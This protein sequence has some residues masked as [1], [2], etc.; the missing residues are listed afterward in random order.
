MQ[1]GQNEQKVLEK[2]LSHLSARKKAPRSVFIILL[3]MYVISAGIVSGTAGSDSDIMIFGMPIPIYSFAGI[4]ASVSEICVLFMTFYCGK[5]GYFTSLCLLILQLPIVMMGIMIQHNLT[6]LPGIFGNLLAISAITIT[7]INNKHIDSYQKELQEQAVTDQLTGLPNRF[8]ALKLLSVLTENK[9]KFAVVSIDINSFK[10]INETMGFETGNDI[11]CEIASRWQTIATKSSSG[12]LDFIAR[13]SGDEFILVIQN[14]Q[15]DEELLDTIRQYEA[16]LS[17]RI[18]MNNSELY[19]TASFGYAKYPLDAKTTD[20]LL[21]YA[22]AAMHEVKRAKSSN[23]IRHFTPDLLKMERTIELEGK[24]RAALDNETIF[25]NLQPQFDMEHKLRGF[26]VLARMRDIDGTFISPGEFIP[27]AEKVGLVDKVDGVVFRKAAMF[28]GELLRKSNADIILS[29]N[30]SVRHL[31]KADFFDE[32]CD[33]LKISG[34]PANKLEIEITESIMIDSVDK[35]L[36]CIDQLRSIGIQIAIDDFGTG[37]SSLS[38]LNRFPANLLKVDKSFID[39]MNTSD[40]A[41]QYIS[42]IISIGHIMGFSVIAEGVED[43]EQVETLREIHCDYIQGYIW[44]KPMMPDDA[45]KL[46]LD[47]MNK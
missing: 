28:F 37:Y 24:I 9:E 12:T 20:T 7:Y 47:P 43:T 35:A 3:V 22:D 31:M 29:I 42:A 14:Y 15:T 2:I 16:V 25:Y 46:V 45:E 44:G 26:E 33:V 32:I 39:T 6:S 38:Y 17:S 27:I 19:I 4:F 18:T 11:I 8:A 21:S 30:V 13:I 40:S 23:H 34:V 36:Q 5:K 41:K 10:G 1:R